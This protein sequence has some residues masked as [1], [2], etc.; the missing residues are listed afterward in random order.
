MKWSTL[1]NLI[2]S[3][4]PVVLTLLVAHATWTTSQLYAC[5]YQMLT[6]TDARLIADDTRQYTD[7]RYEP[8][9]FQLVHLRLNVEEQSRTLTELLAEVRVLREILSED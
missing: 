6:Q 2:V 7:D 5:K 1:N 9:M 4:A 8:I 3:I